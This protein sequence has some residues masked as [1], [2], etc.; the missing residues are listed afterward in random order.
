MLSVD[1]TLSKVY[2][3]LFPLLII[4]PN[5]TV[6]DIKGML[7]LYISI[8]NTP[9][10]CYILIF[11]HNQ[12]FNFLKDK[13]FI[14]FLIFFIS[15]LLSVFV[16]INKAESLMRITD[17]YCILSSLFIICY[18]INN[19][20][21]KPIVLINIVL[22]TFVLD[23]LGSYFQLYQVY[24]IHDI[25]K[26]EHGVDVK[27]FYPN[28][29]ISSFIY[30]TKIII[31]S[32]IPIYSTNRITKILAGVIICSAFYIIFLMSTRALLLMIPFILIFIIVIIVL[33]K[34]F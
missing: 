29:N 26:T 34:Y 25:F 32:L 27:S 19:R 9:F 13:A 20:I 18:F 14:S 31:I 2:F 17:F 4:I 8:L 24:E 22:F 11:K 23:L 15:C 33:K 1:K 10:I 21:I 12:N 30:I 7:W 6:I 16:A 28:K 3:I 5:W